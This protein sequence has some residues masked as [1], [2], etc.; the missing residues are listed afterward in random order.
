MGGAIIS[1]PERV[2]ARLRVE[3]G[4]NSIPQRLVRGLV[5]GVLHKQW[6]PAERVD[7]DREHDQV[8]ITYGTAFGRVD[9]THTIGR[10]LLPAGSLIRD[11]RRL[12]RVR[13]ILEADDVRPRR[14]P[15]PDPLI[16]LIGQ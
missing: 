12:V 5:A 4:R 13:A 3:A 16:G 7:G 6:I 11:A 10:A 8:R 14:P 1:G 2:T 15:E 9:A